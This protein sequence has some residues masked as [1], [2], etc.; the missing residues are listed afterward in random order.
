MSLLIPSSP[1]SRGQ[2]KLLQQYFIGVASLGATKGKWEREREAEKA[3]SRLNI[4]H[5]PLASLANKIGCW[6]MLEQPQVQNHHVSEQ[7]LGGQEW[8]TI[9]LLSCPGFCLTVAKSN[10][11]RYL[12]HGCLWAVFWALSGT[13]WRCQRLCGF[14]QFTPRG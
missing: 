14:Q 13:S 8:W 10:C 11:T 9:Y 1:E 2:G 7:L 3:D 5:L 12:L 6:V 4:T